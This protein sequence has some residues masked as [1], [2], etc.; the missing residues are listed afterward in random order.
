MKFMLSLALLLSL[1]ICANAYF[2][3]PE[4]LDP[5][6]CMFIYIFFQSFIL[7]IIF[8]YFQIHKLP[9]QYALTI[10]SSQQQ[11]QQHHTLVVEHHKP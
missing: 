5:R 11:H 7:I 9:Y 8:V 1:N 2:L 4:I 3:S 6:P 10:L